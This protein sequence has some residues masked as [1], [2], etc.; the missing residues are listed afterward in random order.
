[1][2]SA[3]TRTEASSQAAPRD[4]PRTIGFY[5]AVGIMLGVIIGSGIFR[6]PH[7]VAEELGSPALVLA[8]WVLGG[9]LSLFGALTYTELA[10]VF[11]RSGGLYNFLY[12]GFGARIA[13]IF[14]WTY[15]LI[16]KPFAASAIASIF[17]EYLHLN[18]RVG[19]WMIGQFHLADGF[20]TQWPEPIAVC[21]L[22]VGLTWL[23]A[24]GMRLG[25]GA[26]VVLTTIKALS[27]A[28][29]C[30]L[31]AVL[32]GG[33]VEHFHAV[34]A[35]KPLMQAIAPVMM[36]VLW[37]YDGWSDV[38]AVAG[39]VQQPQRTLPR[40]FLVGTVLAIGLYVAINAA[41]LYV[42]PLEE[43]RGTT[44]VASEVMQRLL[45]RPGAV[46]L[47]AMVLISTLG[48]THASIITGARVTFAQ[49]QD[50]L[51]YKFLSRVHPT[52][53]T[54]DIALWT[55]CLLSCIA[56]LFLKDFSKLAGGFV[57]TIWIFYGMAAAAVIVLRVKRPD[58]VRPYKTPGYPWVPGLF[59]L[60]SLVMTILQIV[61]SPRDTLP[62]VG[63]LAVGWPAFWVWKK[64]VG[65]GE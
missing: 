5:G 36:A 52:R 19:Q 8:A 53:H 65:R 64:V 59:V 54:P 11:P 7:D 35:P 15:M 24:H 43:M 55:Q 25:A 28:A 50:G 46:I 49:S 33:S 2:S 51:L 30:V 26:G 57:F 47:T 12:Q 14:G 18:E 42:L 34:A 48:S 32:P 16:S 27:L 44:A 61:D 56:V 60:A 20:T 40:V 17:A 62:W 23:N 41:Y 63:V 45:G 38:G 6:T 4:L 21:L 10:V 58:L 13:F 39:E 29:I 31:A 37:S 22:L 9:V 1:M 3:P